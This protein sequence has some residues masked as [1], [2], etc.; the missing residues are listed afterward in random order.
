MEFT[1]PGT[2]VAVRQGDILI[3]KDPK[4]TQIEEI[5]LVITADCDI[6]KTKFGRHLACLRVVGLDTYIRTIWASRKLEKLQTDEEEKLR[7]QVAKWHTRQIGS[8]SR[9]SVTATVS[10]VRRDEPF[11]L[12]SALEIPDGEHKKMVSI[13]TNFRAAMSVLDSCEQDDDFKRYVK[14]KAMSNN[15]DLQSCRES[16]ILQAKNDKLPEDAFLL[17]NLPQIENSP[18]V[19][20]LRDIVAVPHGAIFYRTVDVDTNEKY[21]RIGR[22]E[23]T[24]K[25][26]VSQAF[27]SLYSKIGLPSEYE[28]RCID[29]IK[30]LNKYSWE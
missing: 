27:G 28:N 20:L 10:W 26:A 7:G 17:P 24:F 16:V 3:R 12:C 13:L 2:D 5:C 4:S 11:D 8:P 25:Y 29:A 22:L 1:I 14:F 30:S 19:V 21:L 9:L 15:L 6:S 23:P 18:S